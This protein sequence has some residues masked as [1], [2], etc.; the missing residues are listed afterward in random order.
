MDENRSESE[1]QPQSKLKS[2]SIEATDIAASEHADSQT[3]EQG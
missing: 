2:K 1:T 3:T